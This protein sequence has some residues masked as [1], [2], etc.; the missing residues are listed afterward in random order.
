MV[1]A[2]CS[3]QLKSVGPTL[4]D[5]CSS[6][7]TIVAMRPWAP[8]VRAAISGRY[9]AA[10]ARAE[11]LAARGFLSGAALDREREAGL[12]HSARGAALGR[13]RIALA[14]ALASA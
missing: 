6:V 5:S 2:A 4:N 10:A 9:G 11:R 8:V 3:S 13:A 1:G 14:A 7:L 12:E